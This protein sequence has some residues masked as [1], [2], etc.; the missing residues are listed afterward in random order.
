M[1]I[2]SLPMSYYAKYHRKGRQEQLHCM[3]WID[4]HLNNRY[5]Y[6]SGHTSPP[7]STS[8]V[9]SRQKPDLQGHL[10]HPYHLSICNDSFWSS[11]CK[12]MFPI[13]ATAT[14]SQRAPRERP[15]SSLVAPKEQYILGISIVY[16]HSYSLVAPKEP[17]ILG[18]STIHTLW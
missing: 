17:Y 6:E 16:I 10:Q 14:S 15:E 11:R 8:D 13:P 2:I 1:Q 12:G 7:R 9:W 4:S 3:G 18:I 5:S